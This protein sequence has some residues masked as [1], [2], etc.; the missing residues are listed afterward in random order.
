MVG[1][2]FEWPAECLQTIQEEMLCPVLLDTK[3]LNVEGMRTSTR[4][5]PIRIGLE[6]TP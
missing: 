2:P 3:R 6:Q 4:L 1:F 5:K